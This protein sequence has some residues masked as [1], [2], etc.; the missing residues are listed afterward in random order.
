M[1]IAVD[2]TTDIDLDAP[3]GGKKRSEPY[4]ELRHESGKLR[5]GIYLAHPN[6][7]YFIIDKI[8]KDQVDE[9]TDHR[10]GINPVEQLIYRADDSPYSLNELLEVWNVINS[11]LAQRNRVTVLQAAT[12]YLTCCS[13]VRRRP[14]ASS[15][16]ARVGRGDP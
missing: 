16:P 7:G 4:R 11:W 2:L 8:G 6:S 10:I 14:S 12:E 13:Q 5:I 15:P 3:P 1:W 9:R